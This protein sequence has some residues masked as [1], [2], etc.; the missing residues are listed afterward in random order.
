ML[1]C[2]VFLLRQDLATFPRLVSN[3]GLP[4]VEMTGTQHHDRPWKT[5]CLKTKIQRRR[6][7]IQSLST[8]WQGRWRE[9]SS[10]NPSLSIERLLNHEWGLWAR[11]I[12]DFVL[13]LVPSLLGRH[14]LFFPLLFF[15]LFLPPLLLEM[16]FC[17]VSQAALKQTLGLKGS[18][19][20][21]LR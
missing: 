3:S 19:H 7:C 12:K 15:L 11:I 21:C 2:T 1:I 10:W 20:P 5:F 18:F 17:H 4:R 16:E 13:V 8:S 9:R 14:L 6:Q